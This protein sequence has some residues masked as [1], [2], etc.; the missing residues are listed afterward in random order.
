M[1][2]I[3]KLGQVVKGKLSKYIITKEIQETVW[4][5]K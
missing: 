5:A 2:S 1:S 3:F 4:F